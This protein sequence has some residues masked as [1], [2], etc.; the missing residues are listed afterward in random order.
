MSSRNPFEAP[1]GAP[2]PH[3]EVGDL[4]DLEL[5]KTDRGTRWL[6]ALADSLVGLV[7]GVPIAFL[8]VPLADGDPELLSGMIQLGIGLGFLAIAPVNWYFTVT[9]GQ[10]LGKMAVGTRIVDVHGGPVDFVQ[11][12]ILRGWVVAF[13]SMCIPFAGLVDAV[14]IF[15]DAKQCGHDMIAKT[16]VVSA[17]AWNPYSS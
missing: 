8:V 11:G 10:S 13:A 16:I 9:R 17:S 15:G 5:Y 7:I 12:V 6:G 3:S 2:Q 4:E 14:L 1:M